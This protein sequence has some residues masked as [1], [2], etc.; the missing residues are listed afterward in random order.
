MDNV[1]LD[2]DNPRIVPEIE[3]GF[4]RRALVVCFL[5]ITAA[6][7]FRGGYLYNVPEY[8]GFNGTRPQAGGP[9]YQSPSDVGWSAVNC[10]Y[11]VEDLDFGNRIIIPKE[12]MISQEDRIL[13]AADTLRLAR[14]RID[15]DRSRVGR[16]EAIAFSE[17]ITQ[18]CMKH[19]IHGKT[20]PTVQVAAM[21]AYLTHQS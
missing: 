7:V 9:Y 6:L 18:A 14:F 3:R 12:Q 10:A 4:R 20:P 16:D 8:M 11:Y 17:E 15:G 19:T 5:A 1:S 2:P 21:L 13:A